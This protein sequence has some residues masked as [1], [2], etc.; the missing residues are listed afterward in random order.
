MVT[1]GLTYFW[2]SSSSVGRRKESQSAFTSL[3]HDF[4]WGTED[5][6]SRLTLIT[7]YPEQSYQSI[8]QSNLWDVYDWFRSVSDILWAWGRGLWSQRSRDG[9]CRFSEK[10]QLG[11]VQ[12]GEGKAV[13]GATNSTFF[14][15]VLLQ[16]KR[17]WIHSP[18]SWLN[19]SNK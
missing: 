15:R 18:Y 2:T 17:S 14:N 19:A 12:L 1:V 3:F 10:V 8:L 5:L 13:S 16:N 4:H 9:I 11:E 7:Y 6:L